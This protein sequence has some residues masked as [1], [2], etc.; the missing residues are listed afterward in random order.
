MRTSK[1]TPHFTITKTNFLTLFEEIIPDC[2][3]D[4]AKPKST[5]CK[6]IINAGGT[7]AYHWVLKG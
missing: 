2:S 3:E 7:Y 1:K 5:K 6:V 4:H